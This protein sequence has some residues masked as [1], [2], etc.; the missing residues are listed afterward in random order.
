MDITQLLQSFG[1]SETESRVYLKALRQEYTTASEIA[2][3]S[4]I[5][6]P[7]V[8]HTLQTLADKGLI[9]TAGARV[10]KF[11]AQPIEQLI[12]ILDRKK[13]EIEN[14]K[15]EF[16]KA[17]PFF[18]KHNGSNGH[19]PY[20]EYFHGLDG[21]KN[22]VEK[23]LQSRSKIIYTIGA[24]FKLMESSDN[25]YIK[26]F[27]QERA[28]KGIQ[29]KSIWQDM[30]KDTSLLDN[31]ILLRDTRMAPKEMRENSNTMI[32]IVDDVVIVIN[33][34]PEMFGFS[35]ASAGFSKT[36]RGIWESMWNQST[37]VGEK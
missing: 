28:K 3:L 32:S 30:P 36:M 10:E 2:K 14:V 6:R 8:Y 25:Q 27:L 26:H 11:K 33:F 4:G 21:L 37:P 31:K 13:A 23:M 35:V 1:L 20:I 9:S 5:K 17:L 29:T 22:L 16:E 12:V 7:T 24:P 19:I 18:P 34:L 15:N